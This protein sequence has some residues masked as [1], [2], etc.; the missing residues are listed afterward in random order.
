MMWVKW[1]LGWFFETLTYGPTDYFPQQIFH[2]VVIS[3]WIRVYRERREVWTPCALG[4]PQRT[5]KNKF[6]R[7]KEKFQASRKLMVMKNHL[8]KHFPTNVFPNT[9]FQLELGREKVCWGRAASERLCGV[10]KATG[11]A[12][13]TNTNT[14][15]PCKATGP[16]SLLTTARGKTSFINYV[17]STQKH[18]VLNYKKIHAYRTKFWKCTNI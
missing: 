4:P 7:V 3:I 15:E 17:V 12:V 10:W 14:A 9:N 16:T 11:Q 1:K 18:L 13:R 2:V 8:Q 6:P 5:I